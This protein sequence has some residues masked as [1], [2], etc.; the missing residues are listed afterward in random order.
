M[1][2]CKWCDPNRKDWDYKV[3]G[4]DF[5]ELGKYEVDIAVTSRGFLTIDFCQRNL[6][7]PI[8]TI[9]N[10]ITYCPYCGRKLIERKRRAE[11]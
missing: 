3:M 8:F 5:G 1:S 11:E 2:D 7:D 9:N 10:P 6:A 4:Y